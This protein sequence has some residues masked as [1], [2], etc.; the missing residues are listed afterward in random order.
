MRRDIAQFEAHQRVSVQSAA[1]TS[2]SLICSTQRAV[3]ALSRIF[4]HTRPAHSATWSYWQRN[5]PLCFLHSNSDS[6]CFSVARTTLK[7]VVCRWD[8]DPV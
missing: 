8:L 2:V 5:D 6:Q 7:I 1:M 3:L 4:P